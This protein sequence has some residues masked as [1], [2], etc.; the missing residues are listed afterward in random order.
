MQLY[1]KRNVAPR[2]SQLRYPLA[3]RHTRMLERMRQEGEQ[4]LAWHVQDIIVALGLTQADYSLAGGRILHIPEVLSVSERPVGVDIRMLPGQ[5][6]DDFAAH[7]K[8]I[9]YNLNVAKIQVIPLEPS[10]I[11]LI[12][13]PET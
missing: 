4:R 10:L 7:G 12:L 9:A 6:P 11:R 3:R 2:P 13:V 5:M 1:N 8:R